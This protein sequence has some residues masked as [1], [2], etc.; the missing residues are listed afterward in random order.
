MPIPDVAS[1][2]ELNLHLLKACLKDDQRRVSRQRS[3]IGQ[4]WEHE[5]PQLRSLPPFAYDCC[6]T[7][8][9]RLNGYSMIV[10][11]T[12]RYSARVNKD[13]AGVI[14][15]KGHLPGHSFLLLKSELRT[16]AEAMFTKKRMVRGACRSLDTPQRTIQSP[17][18]RTSTCRL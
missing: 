14:C 3:T 15:G 17:P 1:F 9:A 13:N 7:T 11:E 12:N 16:T 5:R 18:L 2:E 4:M 8:S 10:Y 6:A